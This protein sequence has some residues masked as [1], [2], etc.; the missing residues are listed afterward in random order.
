M[1]IGSGGMLKQTQ[2]TPMSESVTG[3]VP[4]NWE[5]STF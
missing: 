3:S 4:R 2:Q 5:W 1:M